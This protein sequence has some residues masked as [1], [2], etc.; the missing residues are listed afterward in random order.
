MMTTSD[1]VMCI[2][3]GEKW[4]PSLIG[5]KQ[6]QLFVENL[7]IS[8]SLPLQE[9]DLMFSLPPVEVT[10]ISHLEDCRYF[11]SQLQPYKGIGVIFF[12]G[13]PFW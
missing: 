8:A 11:R 3:I 12:G 2:K 9:L 5:A 13:T 10:N 4:W 6:E 7:L 1:V